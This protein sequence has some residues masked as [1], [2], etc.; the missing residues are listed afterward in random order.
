MTYDLLKEMI[1]LLEVFEQETGQHDLT[2]FSNWL[3]SI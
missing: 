1:G 3:Y 2:A